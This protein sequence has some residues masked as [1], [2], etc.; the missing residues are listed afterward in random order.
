M[1]RERGGAW[2]CGVRDPTFGPGIECSYIN[3][4]LTAIVSQ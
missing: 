1:E 3:V 2:E 4:V